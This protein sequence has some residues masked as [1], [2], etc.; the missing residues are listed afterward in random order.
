MSE[1]ALLQPQPQLPA[2]VPGG[3]RHSIFQPTQYLWL[4]P[5]PCGGP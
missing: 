2:E 1:F 3:G 5:A 4:R